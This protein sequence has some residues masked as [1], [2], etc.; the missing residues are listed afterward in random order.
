MCINVHN[1]STE[2]VG[3]LSESIILCASISP[4]VWRGHRAPTHP[5]PK[6]SHISRHFLYEISKYTIGQSVS[7][8]KA[9]IT[10]KIC[11]SELFATGN[12]FD[13]FI[14]VRE[15]LSIIWNYALVLLFF[16]DFLYVY[17]SSLQKKTDIINICLIAR[18]LIVLQNNVH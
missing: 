9:T 10:R 14:S 1:F 3:S 4:Q 5:P 17:K 2:R 7:L 8:I 16:V 12:K 6:F 15:T 11:S 13:C 18:N